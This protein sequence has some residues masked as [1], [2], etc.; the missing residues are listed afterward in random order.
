[1]VLDTI[2][3]L[4][5]LFAAYTLLERAAQDVVLAALGRSLNYPTVKLAEALAAVQAAREAT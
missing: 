4:Y 5:D 2:D 1:M 3:A